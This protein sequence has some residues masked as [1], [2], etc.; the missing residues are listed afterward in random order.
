MILAAGFGTRL[1]P[2]TWTMPK[3]IVP[4]CNRP[5][6]AYAVENLLRA[7]IDEII[8]NLHHLPEAIEQFLRDRYDSRCTFAF[9]R[10]EEI[11]GTGGGLRRVRPL[12]ENE[13]DFFLLNGDTIQFPPFAALAEA[14]RAIEAIAALTLRRPP[15]GDRFTPVFFDGTRITGFGD[16]SG[17]SLMFAGC[18]SI[19][20]RIF[21]YLPDRDFSGVVEDS[22][23]PLLAD[24]RESIAA[25]V[26]ESLWF[27]IGTPQRY[28]SASSSLL[29]AMIAGT[30]ELPSGSRIQGSSIVHETARVRGGI[31]RSTIGARTV[32]EGIVDDSFIWDDSHVAIGAKLNSCI[33]S[34]G[35]EVPAGLELSN[36][37]VCRDDAAIPRDPIYR[38]ESGLVIA[39]F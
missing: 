10:E 5:M 34:H 31:S 14:R 39:Q 17:E 19:S 1:R 6:I 11:L 37:I 38:F 13:S 21:R 9:S 20:N 28:I 18:H 26:D 23:K 22:Y 8:V 29:R 32:V 30:I 15:E 35:V 2:V 36:A 27:D 25:I 33:V 4:V 3:P 7:G 12:L 16:G 24:A